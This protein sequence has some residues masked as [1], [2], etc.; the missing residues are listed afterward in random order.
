MVATAAVAVA[1]AVE[2]AAGA[3][4]SSAAVAGS[5]TVACLK[6]VPTT[7]PLVVAAAGGAAVGAV[8]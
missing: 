1:V 5:R 8:D 2:V 7:G 3:S 6:M 4:R